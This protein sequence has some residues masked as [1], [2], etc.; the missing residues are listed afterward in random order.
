[1]GVKPHQLKLWRR[2]NNRGNGGNIS[3]RDTKFLV[4]PGRGKVVVGTRVHTRV[5]S[6]HHALG[7][8]QLS[9]HLSEAAR[10][11]FTINHDRPHTDLEGSTDFGQ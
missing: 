6:D 10:L 3:P 9:A 4:F 2:S 8:T 1:M 5:H 7:A 11:P